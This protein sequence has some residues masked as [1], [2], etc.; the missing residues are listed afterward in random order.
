MQTTTATETTT[1]FRNPA[2]FHISLH[3]VMASDPYG[4]TERQIVEIV[5]EGD[6]VMN[7]LVRIVSGLQDSAI[8]P[9]K[10]QL[11]VE[12][13]QRLAG[14]MGLEYVATTGEG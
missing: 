14:A 10:S 8:G 7:C 3:S 13:L 6:E 2:N 5:P 9:F 1:T 11:A 4:E 12:R